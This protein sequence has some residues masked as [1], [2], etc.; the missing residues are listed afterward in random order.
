MAGSLPTS[1]P[2]PAPLTAAPRRAPATLVGHMAQLISVNAGRVVGVDWA[3]RLDRTAIDKRPI[4]GRVPLHRL[5]VAG[6][7][8]ADRAAHGGVDQAVYAYAREDLDWWADQ[9]GRQLRDGQF[10]ENLTTHGIDVTGAV[11]GE[12]WRVGSALLEV[13]SP[14]TPCLTFQNWLGE[15]AWVRRFTRAARPGGYLRVIQEGDIGAGDLIEV[16]HRPGHG[17]TVGAAFLAKT[18]EDGLVPRL[19]DVPELPSPWHDWARKRLSS[20]A[21]RRS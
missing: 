15:R 21:G 10:G 14:R 11:I 18:G 17:V 4:T 8:Q 6:D 9:L 3:A 19:L 12:R 1:R 20:V 7:E 13:T 2:E 5:G 16:I